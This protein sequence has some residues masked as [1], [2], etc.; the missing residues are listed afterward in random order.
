MPSVQK[1]FSETHV[2]LY[3]A[4][5]GR[6]GRRFK[7]APVAILTTTGRRSG[8]VRETPLLYVRDGD[9]I[10]LV[11]SNGGSD[12]APTWFGNLQADPSVSAQ[13]GK[14]KIDA[15]A[16]VAT[17]DEKTRLWPMVV[18]TYAPY[19]DYQEKTDREIPI[20]ILDPVD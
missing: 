13:I 8:K 7:G 17:P 1:V 5:G 3:K 16:R 10:V 2:F 9:A 19:D 20:V 11:A 14:Q 15:K 4:S 12:T 18:A 6:I